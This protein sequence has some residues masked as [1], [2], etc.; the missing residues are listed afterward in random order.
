M[1]SVIH[2]TFQFR[3]PLY[4]LLHRHSATILP[5][6]EWCVHVRRQLP[7]TWVQCQRRRHPAIRPAC[8]WFSLIDVRCIQ[9][10][11]R[12]EWCLQ[13]APWCRCHIHHITRLRILHLMVF[14]L[15]WC[16]VRCT[17]LYRVQ[18]RRHILSDNR[19]VLVGTYYAVCECSVLYR[20]VVTVL[21]QCWFHGRVLNISVV[22]VGLYFV[23]IMW[24]HLSFAWLSFH[25]TQLTHFV[26]Q[27][28]LSSC[29]RDCVCALF[30]LVI[31]SWDATF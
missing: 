9:S 2:H 13:S 16:I 15:T 22:V 3:C 31:C 19:P 28:Q 21:L 7:C 5:C 10:C 27:L 20:F 6:L 26:A 12:L 4:H 17:C 1:L 29:T 25:R 23:F 18:C 24:Y 8:P 11:R 14:H 30:Q